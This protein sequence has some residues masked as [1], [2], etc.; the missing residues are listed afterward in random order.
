MNTGSANSFN[1]ADFQ[2]FAALRRDAANDSPE[3]RRVVA[4][5]FE[6]MFL[7]L[8][9]S[10]MR[11]ATGIESGL[12]DEERLRPYQSMYDQQLAL[13]LSQHGGIGLA[14]SILRQLGEQPGA[15]VQ[16]SS[17]SAL[18]PSRSAAIERG[19]EDGIAAAR[20]TTR[21]GGSTTR[22]RLQNPRTSVPPRRRSS[23]LRCWPH[24]QRAAAALGVDP[25]VLVAQAALERV[26]APADSGCRR[27]VQLQSL[28]RQGNRPLGRQT[29]P[30][31]D[32]GVRQRRARTPA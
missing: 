26:G 25:E 9:L 3:A 31:G 17:Q 27:R 14:D 6:G 7:N 19:R 4:Q 1:F 20:S 11:D 23:S 18:W 8:L 28:R 32:V 5:Q 29:R 24:A 12:I 16:R 30:G 15:H 2:G 21:S 13:T 10:Q 22:Q